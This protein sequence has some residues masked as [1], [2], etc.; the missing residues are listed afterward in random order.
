MAPRI[1]ERFSHTSGSPKKLR[2]IPRGRLS[3]NSPSG[4]G[5]CSVKKNHPYSDPLCLNRRT[6]SLGNFSRRQ[7]FAKLGIQKRTAMTG[8]DASREILLKRTGGGILREASVRRGSEP[9]QR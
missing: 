5:V 3:W 6:D 2:T 7:R 8:T 9:P 4:S 1:T